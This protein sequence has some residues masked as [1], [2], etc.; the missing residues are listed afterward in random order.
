MVCPLSSHSKNAQLIARD[1]IFLIRHDES[2]KVNHLGTYLS[3][4]DV[5]KHTEDNGGA[6]IDSE[7]DALEDGARYVLVFA[8]SLA[9]SLPFQIQTIKWKVSFPNP[10]HFVHH[11]SKVFCVCYSSSP[12]LTSQLKNSDP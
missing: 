3:W 5:H 8:F 12:S 10:L 4:K 2:G 1:L 11:I 9:N 6:G 7:V